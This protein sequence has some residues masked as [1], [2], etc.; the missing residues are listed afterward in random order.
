MWSKHQIR[1]AR[2]I[3]LEPLL[4]SMGVRLHP[5]KNGN[6][7]VDDYPG[8]VVK[9]HFWT[10]PDRN[11]HGNA[12]DFL[13]LVCEKSFHQAMQIITAVREEPPTQEAKENTAHIA[14]HTNTT[15]TTGTIHDN[16]TG[17]TQK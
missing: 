3:E 10:W 2:K 13:V 7:L 11:I 4:L 16:S 8:L 17:I 15:T 9:Q 14:A 5:L 12:I 6:A 1:Q